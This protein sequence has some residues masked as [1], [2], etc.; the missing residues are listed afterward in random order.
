MARIGWADAV[1]VEAGP[2]ARDWGRSEPE[3]EAAG[4]GVGRAA[5]EPARLDLDELNRAVSGPGAERLDGVPAGGQLPARRLRDRVFH[6]HDDRL[7]DRGRVGA[8]G[9]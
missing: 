5:Q 1:S 3:G 8:G 6:P 2:N 7:V 9:S 4:A